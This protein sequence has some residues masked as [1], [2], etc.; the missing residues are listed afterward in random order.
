[1][2]RLLVVR[3]HPLDAGTSRT[4]RLTDEFVDAYRRSHPEDS[5]TDL[6]LY[7]VAIP[8]IDLDLLSGWHSLKAGT[9]F[10]HLD[11]VEQVKITLFNHYTEQFME[12][13]KVVIANPLW[14]LQVPTRLKAWIDTISVAGVTFKYNQ[15]GEGVGLVRGKR[16]AHIQTAG[17]VFNGQDPASAYVRTLFRF[18]GVEDFHELRAEGMDHDPANADDIMAAASRRVVE[19]AEQF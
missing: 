5:V 13:D 2:T 7:E 10:V 12:S 4:M 14:N 11:Q 19:L 17:G 1:M 18:L 9:P 8:E 6:H 3:A 16:V 15:E